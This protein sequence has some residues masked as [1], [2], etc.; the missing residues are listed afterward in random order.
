MPLEVKLAGGQVQAGIAPAA[1]IR[2]RQEVATALVVRVVE[3]KPGKAFRKA[4]A[5]C[6]VT[7]HLQFFEAPVAAASYGIR[8]FVAA[9]GPAALRGVGDVAFGPEEAVAEFLA[10]AAAAQAGP[11]A[12]RALVEDEAYLKAFMLGFRDMA[13]DGATVGTVTLS[14]PTFRSTLP[15][16]RFEPA[17]RQR[18][19]DGL[20]A[21]LRGDERV[22]MEGMLK[23][24]NLRARPPHI[25]V[26]T[27][28]GDCVRFFLKRGQLDDT[29]G[30]KLNCRVRVSGVK[31]TKN[32]G[33][34]VK[35]ALDVVLVEP[36]PRDDSGV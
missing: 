14:T 20:L 8:L 28:D 1:V 18:L 2:E 15:P 27:A 31:R 33:T 24:V 23:E 36:E 34:V 25:G 5:A 9:N 13:P 22:E 12:L 21:Q 4:G 30:P 32:D 3:W 19:T 10:I 7:E 6:E 11:E 16:L 35:N 29:I 17:H 26:E